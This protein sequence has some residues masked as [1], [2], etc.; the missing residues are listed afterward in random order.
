[1][2]EIIKKKFGNKPEL[3][4]TRNSAIIDF[5]KPRLRFLLNP[6]T[7]IIALLLFIFVKNCTND[8]TNDG[9]VYFNRKD[10]TKAL[11]LY[12][13]YLM[14]NPHH[15]KTLYN[16]GRCYEAL[17]KFALATKDYEYVLKKEPHNISALLSLSQCYYAQENYNSAA[18]LCDQAILIDGQNDLAHYYKGR[19][20]H[21]LGK[22]N[23]AIDGY[24]SAIDINP[25]FGFAYFQRS[26]LLLS[27]GLRPFA[28]YDLK[29][30][31]SLDVKG[32]KAALLKY[33]R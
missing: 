2:K 30:A 29:K 9:N 31:D 18:N 20:Y 10:Y 8:S 3:S 26:S 5:L 21:K 14:L 12:N 23:D 16:R 27:V 15:I 17:G 11:E 28:C 24:N 6:Y 32:A 25:E 4:L 22:F 33:C 19:A 7:L 1:M 13:E